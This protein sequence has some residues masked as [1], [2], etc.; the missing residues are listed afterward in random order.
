MYLHRISCI[1][2]RNIE[3]CDLTFSDKLN[4]FVGANG[5]G[6]TNLLDAI[7][8]LSFTKSHLGNIDSQ[9][10]R[11]NA[12]Y[13]MIQ[14][15]YMRSG[16]TETITASVR[17]RMKKQFHRNKKEYPRMADHIGFL[18]A[19]L[20]SPSDC[21][22]ITEGSDE[23]RRFMD[24]VISQYDHQYMHSLM[25]YNQALQN[26]NALLK[27]ELCP[28]EM[29]LDVVERQMAVE[30]EYIYSCRRSFVDSFTPVFT[31]FYTSIAGMDEHVSLIYTS[32]SERGDLVP[33]LHECRERDFAVGYTTRG[34]HKDDLEMLLDGYPIKRTGSQG[35]NKTYLVALKLAQYV[36]LKRIV[37]IPPVL[38]LDDIFDRLDADRVCRIIELV[39]S[40]EFGQ[41][42]ITDTNRNNID[43]IISRF[44]IHAGI[45]TLDH[46][47][48]MSM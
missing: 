32:H 8:Y 20:I 29:M 22:L 1:N 48:V 35:Q 43:R 17:R 45:F 10:I 3:Q 12:E 39:S 24:V 44:D 4:C 18:P 37:G 30:A 34:A 33:L 38:L 14:G 23:R 40:G 2:Y 9:L 19:V 11:H 15:E 7:Y 42:F 6:K 31:G 26:R 13:F 28:D 25:R 46:G 36:Y 5:M 27:Q 41:I 16:R 21:D 47:N